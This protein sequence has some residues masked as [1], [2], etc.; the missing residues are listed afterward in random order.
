MPS[1][2]HRDGV[3][4]WRRRVERLASELLA[5]E[6]HG[7]ESIFAAEP[8]DFLERVIIEMGGI[9]ELLTQVF[10]SQVTPQVN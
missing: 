4:A 9:S 5:L 3:A 7:F 10:F 1:G 2:A 8:A 6:G